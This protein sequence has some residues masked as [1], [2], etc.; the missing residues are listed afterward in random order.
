MTNNT[1]KEDKVIIITGDMREALQALIDH[2]DKQIEQDRKER[3]LRQS[4]KNLEEFAEQ[5]NK[6]FKEEDNKNDK[7]YRF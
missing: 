3:A 1:P 4:I 5:H 2:L 6:K 7:A